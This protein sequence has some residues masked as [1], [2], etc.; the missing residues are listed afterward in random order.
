MTGYGRNDWRSI[1]DTN[2]FFAATSRREVGRTRPSIRPISEVKLPKREGG[3]LSPFNAEV[4]DAWS[5]TS[6]FKISV[7]GHG[8]NSRVHRTFT[9]G[10]ISPAFII[11][12]LSAM[13][14]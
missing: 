10:L 1:R 6:T 7:L 2:V 12:L 3:H 9:C 13:D 4:K 8:T 14:G 5:F 11:A